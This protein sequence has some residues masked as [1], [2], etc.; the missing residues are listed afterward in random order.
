MM[1]EDHSRASQ[2]VTCLTGH[3]LRLPAS[4]FDIPQTL[5]PLLSQLTVQRRQELLSN[6]RM[7][8]PAELTASIANIDL[9]DID[10]SL[11]NNAWPPPDRKLHVAEL[12]AERRRYWCDFAHL[13][14]QSPELRA[15]DVWLLN[16]FDLGMARS[17]QKHTAR[18]LAYALGL[19]YAWGAAFVELTNGNRKEQQR[20]SGIT[21]KW[22]R[23]AM[24]SFRGGRSGRARL[25]AC[26][27]WIHCTI[28]GGRLPKVATRGGWVGEWRSSL[29]QG[30]PHSLSLS[31]LYTCRR[32][33][34]V[35][36]L[37]QINR[38]ISY[39]GT[40]MVQPASRRQCRRC[41]LAVIRGAR[42]APGWG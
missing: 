22:A 41:C 13:I 12:N 2:Q 1:N 23:T 11:S 37:T 32:L 15:V 42:R 31:V 14:L 39:G 24:P 16:E 7:L 33:G 5:Q 30:H 9:I 35:T 27:E 10:N 28:A 25:S 18:R 8:T 40:S 3:K 34:G 6:V 4:A 20:T 38:S 26:L 29:S 21:N 19:N 36:L 17:G